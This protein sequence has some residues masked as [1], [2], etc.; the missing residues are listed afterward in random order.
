VAAGGPRLDHLA[1]LWTHWVDAADRHRAAPD[2]EVVR[3]KLAG[4]NEVTLGGLRAALAR[5]PL[6]QAEL[7]AGLL[8]LLGRQ[9]L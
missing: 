1:E 3:R 7:R 4:A 5:E 6:G 9:R 2:R 8:V